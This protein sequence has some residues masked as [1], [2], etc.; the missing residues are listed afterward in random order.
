[1]AVVWLH[2]LHSF[3]SGSNRYTVHLSVTLLKHVYTQN[4]L[5]VCHIAQMQ[6]AHHHCHTM[7]TVSGGPLP[8]YMP[9]VS[10]GPLPHYAHC[11]RRPTATLHLLSQ[12]VHSQ[13]MPATTPDRH[14]RFVFQLLCTRIQPL[15][16]AVLFKWLYV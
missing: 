4:I 9:T 8:H 1:M 7:P 3:L 11:L 13:C 14:T 15:I 10:G 5:T 6:F 16:R 2:C 12:E